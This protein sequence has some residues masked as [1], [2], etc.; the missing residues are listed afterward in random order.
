MI[1]ASSTGMSRSGRGAVLVVKANRPDR[2]VAVADGA[3][4]RRRHEPRPKIN[5]LVE[6]SSLTTPPRMSN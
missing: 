1:T 4:A 6:K 2:R 3:G 5:D